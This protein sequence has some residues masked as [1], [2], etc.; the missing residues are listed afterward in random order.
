MVH[1]IPGMFAL[2]LII[3]LKAEQ[4]FFPPLPPPCTDLGTT[5]P[6]CIVLL[7]T[8]S[9][10]IPQIKGKMDLCTDQNGRERQ[11]GKI[12]MRLGSNKT[13][14]EDKQNQKEKC[15]LFI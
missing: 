8:L 4:V 6:I 15:P 1:L 5:T 9:P 12:G 14:E 3:L 11:R 10:A 7:P 2:K 13:T